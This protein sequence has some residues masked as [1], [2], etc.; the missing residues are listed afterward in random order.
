MG[1]VASA[2][3]SPRG[4]WLA[5]VSIIDGEC[6][7]WRSGSWQAG[8][9]FPGAK[10][11]AFSPD[12]RIAALG[13]KPGQI[14]LCDTETG[15]EFGI[16]PIADGGVARPR[17]FSPDGTRLHATVGR[18]EKIYT[19]D[20]LQIRD[21]LRE[22]GLDQGWPEFPPRLDDNS[23]PIVELEPGTQAWRL[24]RSRPRDRIAKTR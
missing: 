3:F 19:W 11:I 24:E 15:R 2:W 17:C 20:L 7:L 8:P 16:L 6:R 23:P 21:G 22:L 12:E 9:R 5:T 18:E 10:D 4:D 1:E 13:G 14:Q